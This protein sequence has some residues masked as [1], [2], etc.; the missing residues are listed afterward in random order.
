MSAHDIS[1]LLTASQQ[2]GLALQTHQA[3]RLLAYVKLLEKWNKVHNLT[4]VREPEKMVTH[5]L[6]DSLAV[7]PYLVQ[8]S[9]V[10]D[11]GSGGGLPGIP[12]AI[13]QPEVRVTLL[14]SN[15]KKTSFLQ[16]AVIELA[17][18][19]VD[20]VT[21][22]VEQYEPEGQYAGIICRAF[23]E[24]AEVIRLTQSVLA[25]A[26]R[27]YM[28]KGIYP[29]TELAKLPTGVVVKAVHE[30]KVPNLAASRHLLVLER[31]DG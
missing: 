10:L 4:A 28:M 15:H 24:M 25:P 7:V 6:L 17:L 14:D 27:W 13:V 26:G 29:E 19:N 21:A 20:V 5:H 30:L 23:A 1:G 31:V 8:E 2:M 11:V 18:S 16:Q 12:L 9:R 3:E 22:R